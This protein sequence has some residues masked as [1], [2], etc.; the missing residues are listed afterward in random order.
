MDVELSAA[1]LVPERTHSGSCADGD[2]PYASALFEAATKIVAGTPRSFP[3]RGNVGVSV[4]SGTPLPGYDG[5]DAATAIEE[6]LVD[7]GLLEDERQVEVEWHLIDSTLQD[8]YIVVV[9][10]RED[11]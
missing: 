7:A 9:K 8:R 5:Y 2:S 3:L 1:G 6:V 10:P 4:S 11:E